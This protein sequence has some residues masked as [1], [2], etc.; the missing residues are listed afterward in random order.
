MGCKNWWWDTK[1]G[2]RTTT[3]TPTCVAVSTSTIISNFRSHA[4]PIRSCDSLLLLLPCCC[5]WLSGP[6]FQ[7]LD[8]W[9][10]R[11][12]VTDWR[13]QTDG[14]RWTHAQTSDFIYKIWKLKI[15]SGSRNGY[16]RGTWISIWSLY[17]IDIEK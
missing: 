13:S 4:S 3:Q 10:S 2:E 1:E 9:L 11:L 17:R 15:G 7:D 16:R 5:I 8:I 6:E 12:T 14:H